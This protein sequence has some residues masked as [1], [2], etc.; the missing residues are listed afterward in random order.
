MRPVGDDEDADPEPGL[1]LGSV[2][3]FTPVPAGDKPLPREF[4]I[5]FHGADRV[6]MPKLPRRRKV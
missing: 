4:P 5:G 1:S 3:T 2:A 6:D